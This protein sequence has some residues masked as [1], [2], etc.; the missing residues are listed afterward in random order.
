MQ[1]ACMRS[2]GP[3]GCLGAGPVAMQAWQPPHPLGR[4]A[5]GPRA[6]QE[7]VGQ[8]YSDLGRGD[9]P[10][11]L[12]CAWGHPGRCLAPLPPCGGV[13]PHSASM[14]GGRNPRGPQCPA[15]ALPP[16][17]HAQAPP[18]PPPAGGS[19]AALPRGLAHGSTA[20]TG[21]QGQ[22]A[23]AVL[24]SLDRLRLPCCVSITG[25]AGAVWRLR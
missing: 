9:A 12:S 5:G 8:T 25:S 15:Q 14:V 7:G 6:A 19:G 22:A 21:R 2:P 10:P 23:A 24:R 18:S 4:A 3:T 16:S 17:G 11:G 13:G 20:S 1:G